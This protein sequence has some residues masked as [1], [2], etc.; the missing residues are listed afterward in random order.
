MERKDLRNSQ[1]L[2]FS[3][4]QNFSTMYKLCTN[5]P[6]IFSEKCK[7]KLS[8]FKKA[9]FKYSAAR[10]ASHVKSISMNIY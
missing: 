7:R 1:L 9:E 4:I 3:L 2:I 5:Q 8:E 10:R 6:I